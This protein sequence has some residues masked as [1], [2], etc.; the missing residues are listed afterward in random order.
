MK[1]TITVTILAFC[2]LAVV[3]TAC[4]SQL[5][6]SD[7]GYAELLVDNLFTGLQTRDYAV[8]S[9]DFTPELK[10]AITETSFGAM[11]DQLQTVIGKYESRKFY[12]ASIVNKNN[13]RFTVVVYNAKFSGEP[14]VVTV[15][16][17]FQ[18]IADQDKIAGLFFNSPKLQKAK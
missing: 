9:R 5:A 6:P 3:C 1:H 8:F 14:D 7:V 15:T 18:V 11:A 12:K 2:L 4:V 16:V 13:T 10:A 17:T